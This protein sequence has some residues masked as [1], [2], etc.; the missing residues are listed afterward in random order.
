MKLTWG[1]GLVRGRL[2][3]TQSIGCGWMEAYITDQVIAQHL[4]I[5]TKANNPLET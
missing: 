2:V 1:Y 3:S 4:N 5:K